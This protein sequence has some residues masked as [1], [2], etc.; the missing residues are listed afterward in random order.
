[1]F[2]L[3]YFREIEGGRK[4]EKE[5]EREREREEEEKKKKK[6]KMMMMMMNTMILTGTFFKADF[7]NSIQ[8]KQRIN[9]IRNNFRFFIETFSCFIKLQYNLCLESTGGK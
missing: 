5:R 6:K 2:L 9:L 8:G 4:R 1:M 3:V 7:P